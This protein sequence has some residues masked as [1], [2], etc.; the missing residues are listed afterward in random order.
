MQVVLIKV[1]I[2][3]SYYNFFIRFKFQTS[4]KGKL[5]PSSTNLKTQFYFLY[6]PSFSWTIQL[7]RSC[8]KFYFPSI[9]TAI[10]L[11]FSLHYDSSFTYIWTPSIAFIT[12]KKI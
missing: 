3:L 6:P 5:A 2:N 1:G 7:F 11:L 9:T 10:F 8:N 12:H 4:F